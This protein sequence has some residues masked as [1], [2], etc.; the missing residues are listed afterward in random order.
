M[1]RDL[2]PERLDA[3]RPAA[4]RLAG[5]IHAGDP[6]VALAATAAGVAAATAGH[7]LVAGDAAVDRLAAGEVEVEGDRLLASG[8]EV[9]TGLA[10]NRRGR[11][12]AALE[13]VRAAGAAPRPPASRGEPE[14]DDPV[15]LLR[16]L[17]ELRDRGVI[18]P[19]EFEAKKAELL[20]R[21]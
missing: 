8:R 2:P 12:A 13:L 14:H 3:A 4:A 1:L 9:A 21:I 6:P 5:A 19:A 15:E 11:L 17:G 10:E 16:R 7:V 20:R 18:E